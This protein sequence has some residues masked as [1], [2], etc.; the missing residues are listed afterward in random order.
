MQPSSER[1]D[2]RRVRRALMSLGGPA[3]AQRHH[4]RAGLLQDSCCV[5]EEIRGH[6]QV[7]EQEGAVDAAQASQLRAVTDRLASLRLGWRERLPAEPERAGFDF[8]WSDA[9]ED[10]EW[11]G[12][13]RVAR[14]A[15]TAMRAPDNPRVG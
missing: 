12:L 13:R 10:P 15:F 3:Q 4:I 2:L 14:S 1:P 9:L 11:D 8:V 7:M 5:M 6:L